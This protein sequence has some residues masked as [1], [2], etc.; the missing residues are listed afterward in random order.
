MKLPRHATVVAY[1]ALFC[2]LTGG[3]YAAITLP[4]NSVGAKQIKTGAVSSAK[5]ADGSLAATDFAAGQLPAGEKG[6]AGAAGAAGPT[7][8]AGAKGEPGVAG[9]AGPTG[10]TGPTGADGKD[11][12]LGAMPGGTAY[13]L[14]SVKD[15]GKAT[16]E[17][18]ANTVPDGGSKENPV[19]FAGLT[20][21]KLEGLKMTTDCT[22]GWGLVIPKPGVYTVSLHVLW[23]VDADGWRSI[24]LSR[25]FGGNADYL[26]ET[27]GPAAAGTVTGQ[28]VTYTGRFAKDDLVQVYAIQT[29]GAALSTIGDARTSLNIQYVAP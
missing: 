28:N 8:P 3:A 23:A 27:R 18:D 22:V 11:A 24:G 25:R 4:K 16:C 1:L 20:G 26:G 5:V 12:T 10:P 21:S 6:A 9:P 14:F 13:G 15:T 29:S 2:A 7:G 19:A 17:Y